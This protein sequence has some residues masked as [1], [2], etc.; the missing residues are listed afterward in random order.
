MQNAVFNAQ[1]NRASVTK[2][3]GGYSNHN[4]GIAWD[5]AIFENG[6]YRPES[7][8]YGK[9][10]EIERDQ[11]LEWGGDWKSIQDEPHFNLKTGLTTAQLRSAF[12]KGQGYV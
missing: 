8:H 6:A 10:G 1:L 4:F 7:L 2:A 5:I 9:A 12:L 3:K 11:G